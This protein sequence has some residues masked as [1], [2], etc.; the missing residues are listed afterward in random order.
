[1]YVMLDGRD[2]QAELV[3]DLLIGE[4]AA[5]QFQHLALAPGQR[6]STISQ[7]DLQAASIDASRAK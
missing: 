6:P 1:M 7:S 4:P 2:S 5:E 3:A